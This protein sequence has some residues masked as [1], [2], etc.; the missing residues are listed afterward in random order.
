MNPNLL[1]L[2]FCQ[3]LLNSGNALLISTSALS[4]KALAGSA[5][6]ATLPVALML[7][8]GTLSSFPASYFMKRYGRRSGFIFGSLLGAAG[9]FLLAE[10]VMGGSFFRFVVGSVIVGLS[11]GFS[12]FYRFA[13]VEAVPSEKR[14][15]AISIVL[16]G[17]VIA[18][19]VGPNLAQAS[20]EW[21]SSYV[22]AGSYFALGGLFLLGSL[23][24]LFLNLPKV[25]PSAA[26]G[27]ARPIFEIMA[28][29]EWL[30]AVVI[31]ALGFVV[32]NLVM[33]ATPLAMK[34]H[35]QTFK[36]TAFVIQW[37]MVGMFVPSFFTGHLIRFLG[38]RMV[39]LLGVLLEAGCAAVNQYGPN[40]WTYT[41]S[42]ILLG[43]GWNF[44]FV[45][46]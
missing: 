20:R 35:E 2:F 33:T 27:T 40:M 37:H 19:F 10:A 17:G 41:T 39:L 3:A 23:A 29:R 26:D 30:A 22:F 42:L 44:L 31:G 8:S 4:G 5:T 45:G 11:G 18:A 9:S 14:S 1:I 13:A 36:D 7:F 15:F 6:L 24:L 34:S 25:A 43:V 38:L 28:Q 16:A 46:A 12:T 32:M 21:I